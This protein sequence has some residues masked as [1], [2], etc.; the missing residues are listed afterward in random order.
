M[1]HSSPSSSAP[2]GKRMAILSDQLAG[3]IGG[4]ESILFAAMDLRPDADVYTT[5]QRPGLVPEPYGSK[6][7]RTTWIQNLPKAPDLYKAY[8]PLMPLAVEMLNLQ[9]YDQLFTSH[10][11]V[12]KGIIPRPDAYHACYCHS[13]A[14][15]LWDLFWTY[16]NL[17][18]FGAIKQVMV[19][20][21][22]QYMRLWDVT[23]ANRVDLFIANSTITAKRIKKFYQ[24]ES[25]IIYPPVDTHRFRHAG[26][27][28]YY[29]MVGRLVAYKG[30]ELAID[31]FNE[32]KQPLV[33]IGGGP[34]YEKLKAKAGPT[35]KLLGK[36][37]N[38]TLEH[39]M[40]HCKGFIYPGKEDFGIVMVEAQSAGKPVIALNAGGAQDIVIPGETG[41]LADTPSVVAFADAVRQANAMTWDHAAIAQHA[42]KYDVTLFKQ[43]LAQVFE[44]QP[45][46]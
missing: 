16:S 23:S 10:H 14:R 29:L 41:L 39:H 26:T 15:Y 20:A 43:Q 18:G 42:Q 44:Q 7:Q 24:R 5:V 17:N 45:V 11:S 46:L 40:N 19:A 34:E 1:Q 33:I 4:A 3:G 27:E 30:F 22:S 38:A 21:V 8:L 2:S 35:V 13:P 36:V 6:I 28:D 32:L 12:I 31:V 25:H 37:D 9:E